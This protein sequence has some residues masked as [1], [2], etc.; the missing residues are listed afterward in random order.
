MSQQEARIGSLEEHAQFLETDRVRRANQL[1]Y[2]QGRREADV[3]AHLRSHE[4]RLDA[5]NGSIEKHARN[6]AKLE[7]TM[8]KRCD[9]IED[10]LDALL[11]ANSAREAVEQDRVA[12]VTQANEQSISKRS[13]W[14]GIFGL[15]VAILMLAAT[16]LVGTHVL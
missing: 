4:N 10:K 3:D 16:V 14:L 2:A 6:V 15:I 1:A 8:D 5:I 12:Q 9:T 11:T 7:A 13:Y